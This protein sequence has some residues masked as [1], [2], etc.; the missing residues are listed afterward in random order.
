MSHNFPGA[1][2]LTRFLKMLAIFD[3]G[4]TCHTSQMGDE[5]NKM[6]SFPVMDGHSRTMERD[7]LVFW[8]VP[9]IFHSENSNLFLFVVSVPHQGTPCSKGEEVT[10]CYTPLPRQMKS[11]L[12][13][14]TGR[15]PPPTVVW[16][17]IDMSQ[18]CNLPLL[19]LYLWVFMVKS[20]VWI[21]RSK[22][23]ILQNRPNFLLSPKYKNQ[24]AFDEAR[25]QSLLNRKCSHISKYHSL[26]ISSESMRVQET[27]ET[28]TIH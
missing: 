7:P 18:F 27:Y 8:H 25:H 21:P 26:K 15:T 9:R 2:P 5:F 19:W 6:K 20:D 1:I 22:T 14:L 3:V 11:F 24:H 28:K 23:K 17:F 12:A 4:N 16:L 13:Y 10:F